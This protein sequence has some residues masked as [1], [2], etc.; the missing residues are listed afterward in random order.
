MFRYPAALKETSHGLFRFIPQF[1]VKKNKEGFFTFP[2]EREES[3]FVYYS[4][5]TDSCLTSRLGLP[6]QLVPGAWNSRSLPT[7]STAPST[8]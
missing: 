4:P 8:S 7:A 3:F 6:K 5:A 2:P 1:S